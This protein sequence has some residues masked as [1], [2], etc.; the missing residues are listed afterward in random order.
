MEEQVVEYKKEM[1]NQQYELKNIIEKL[2]ESKKKIKIERDQFI[3]KYIPDIQ[4]QIQVKCEEIVNDYK[5][6][7]NN[8]E[9]EYNKIKEDYN[10]IKKQYCELKIKH[11]EIKNRETNNRNA[12]LPLLEDCS[13]DKN[14]NI[15]ERQI[16]KNEIQNNAYSDISNFK[17]ESESNYSNKDSDQINKKSIRQKMERRDIKRERFGNRCSPIEKAWS[18]MKRKLDKYANDDILLLD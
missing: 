11:E 18:T 2:N 9:G 8:K 15:T 5:T 12:L 17:I 3:N 7:I 14:N 10:E 16:N 1:K 4:I 6:L 13:N